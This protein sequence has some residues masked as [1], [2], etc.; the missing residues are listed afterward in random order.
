MI[1]L[2]EARKNSRRVYKSIGRHWVKKYGIKKITY[3]N[4]R[5]YALTKT[6]EIFI[7]S[8]ITRLRL[9]NLAHEIGHVV[10]QHYRNRRLSCVMEYEAEQFSL[11][12]MKRYKIKF[13]RKR[14]IKGKRYVASK[15][16]MAK[17]RGLKRP[18]PKEVIKWVK[19]LK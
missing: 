8:P 16:D 13:P 12:L 19:D 3:K 17:R 2:V 1:N 6:R 14:L 10:L 9:C 7:P 18:V 4:G 15:I 11:D 5:G